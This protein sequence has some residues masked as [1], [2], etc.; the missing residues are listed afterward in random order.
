[1]YIKVYTYIYMC[2]YIYTQYVYIHRNIYIYIYIYMWATCWVLWS[3]RDIR[4]PSIAA[5]LGGETDSSKRLRL[6]G[7]ALWIP[8]KVQAI[9]G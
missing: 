4:A 6:P 8:M 2:I 5:G 7:Q 3:S 1:M 9:G